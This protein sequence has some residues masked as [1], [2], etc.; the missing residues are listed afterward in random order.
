ML[1]VIALTSLFGYF[2]IFKGENYKGKSNL[3]LFDLIVDYSHYFLSE[4]IMIFIGKVI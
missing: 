3:M 4:L 2:G 1:T